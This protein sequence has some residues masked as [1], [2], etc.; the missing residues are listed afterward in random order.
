VPSLP[1]TPVEFGGSDFEGLVGSFPVPVLVDFHSAGC[2]PCHALAPVLERVAGARS[3]RLV[4]LKVSVDANPK[5]ASGFGVRSVPTL[6]VMR[7]G[8][9]IDRIVGAPSEDEIL[10]WVDRVSA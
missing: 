7:N 3:G 8:G 10:H 9:E 1:S 5:I 2:G 6:V 4:V